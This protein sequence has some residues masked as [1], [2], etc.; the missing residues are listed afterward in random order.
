MADQKIDEQKAVNLEN[1]I[2]TILAQEEEIHIV[3][4]A[5]IVVIATLIVSTNSQEKVFEALN[6]T[7]QLIRDTTASITKRWRADDN[8][9]VH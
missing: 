8:V 6:L 4:S 3:M 2:L 9:P 7:D 5:L 1:Q